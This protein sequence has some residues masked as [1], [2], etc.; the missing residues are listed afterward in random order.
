[1]SGLTS[2]LTSSETDQ[3]QAREMQLLG[4]KLPASQLNTFL[5]RTLMIRL[6]AWVL[7]CTAQ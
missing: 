6:F 1:M 7:I 3:N 2:I 4:Y 5:R